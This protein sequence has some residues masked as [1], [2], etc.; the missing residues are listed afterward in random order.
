MKLV[1][2]AG[3]LGTRIAEESEIRPKPMIEIGERPLI[4]HIMKIYSHYGINDFV[5][6][7][8]YKGYIIKE[9]FRNY[10]LHCSDIA[11]DLKDNSL[12]YL[13]ITTE[14]WVLR[15]V[16]TGA[17]T[18]TGGRLKRVRNHLPPNEPFCLT[19]GDAVS[20][21]DIAALIAFHK[22]HGKDA[23][24]LAVAP[25]GRWGALEIENQTVRR[26]VEKPA[27]D[28]AFI[29][30]G[31]FVLQPSVIDRIEDDTTPWESGPLESLARDG[32]LQ[33]FRHDGFWHAVD[34]LREKRALEQLWASG[35][36]PWKVWT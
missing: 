26:F 20:N 10:F 14:P 23:T 6:C 3:G 35:N 2:L 29:S 17:G 21:I 34:T 12:E 1:I 13:K 19:Y 16:D 7:L 8:G 27:G 33:A 11:I 30:G 22:R 4:W 9:Y 31:F 24:V 36:P 15:L 5:I 25:P 18:Q 28:S 32:E